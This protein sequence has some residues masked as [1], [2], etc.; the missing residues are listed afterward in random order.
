MEGSLAALLDFFEYNGVA[1]ASIHE[2][3]DDLLAKQKYVPLMKR[4]EEYARLF[5]V[6]SNNNNKEADDDDDKTEAAHYLLLNAWKALCEYAH[7]QHQH[8]YRSFHVGRLK[9]S[10]K[11]QSQSFNSNYYTS[12]H[13]RHHDPEERDKLTRRMSLPNQLVALTRSTSAPITT[14]QQQRNNNI[15]T[16]QQ[17][18]QQLQLQ[19]L[20]L[21]PLQPMTLMEL[22]LLAEQS[23]ACQRGYILA[24]KSWA[25][26]VVQNS[27]S[28]K[29]IMP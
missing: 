19:Q 14:T 23:C 28:N 20:D 27:N 7:I 1:A 6:S 29:N 11:R 9:D 25:K 16:P 24:K 26:K 2:L 18:Q 17:Q 10:Q 21:P 3:R 5:L 15:S 12:R 22:T 13:H 8:A 4:L